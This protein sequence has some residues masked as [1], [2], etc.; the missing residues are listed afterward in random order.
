[1]SASLVSFATY[2]AILRV[3]EMMANQAERRDAEIRLRHYRRDELYRSLRR[4]GLSLE[5]AE[6]ISEQVWEV[7]TPWLTLSSHRSPFR[8][9]G[10][11]A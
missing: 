5:T 9:V 6:M 2:M 8:L 7:S 1:M 4:C 10:F 11:K 3:E